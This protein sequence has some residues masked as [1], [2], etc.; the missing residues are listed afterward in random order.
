M[1]HR[2]V[3]DNAVY[4]YHRYKSGGRS[5]GG[6][7]SATAGAGGGTSAAAGAGGGAYAVYVGYEAER[8]GQ[9]VS[10][11]ARLVLDTVFGENDDQ[12]VMVSGVGHYVTNE[13]RF[14]GAPM[15]IGMDENVSSGPLT[16]ITMQDSRFAAP[17]AVTLAHF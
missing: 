5:K 17:A 4:K 16:F 6:G 1:V 14:D 2:R 13:T 15:Y 8:G 11:E 9:P 12:P 7:A 3:C 10:L